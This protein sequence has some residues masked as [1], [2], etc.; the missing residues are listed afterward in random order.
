MPCY[1]QHEITILFFEGKANSAA[2]IKD[3]HHKHISD[4]KLLGQ[5]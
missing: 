5:K 3:A 4:S 1:L 2:I